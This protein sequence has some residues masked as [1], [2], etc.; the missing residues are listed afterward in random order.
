V[1]PRLSAN[2]QVAV[3]FRQADLGEAAV[4]VAAGVARLEEAA[5]VCNCLGVDWAS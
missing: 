2:A 4:R 1:Q 3:V 5:A